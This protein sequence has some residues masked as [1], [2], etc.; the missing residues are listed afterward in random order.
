MT[1]RL[2]KSTIILLAC[3]LAFAAT[4]CRGMRIDLKQASYAPAFDAAELKAYKGKSVFIYDIANNAS[5]TSL[6]DYYSPTTRN[7]YEAWPTMRTYFWDCFVKA[8]N[9][10]G[11]TVAADGAGAPSFSLSFTTLNEEEMVFDVNLAHAGSAPFVKNYK[12]STP[13]ADPKADP[14]S[15]EKRAYRQVDAAFLAVMT[16][17][18][19]RK[20]F[21][22]K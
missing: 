14:A 20:A 4:G 2:G 15:L 18:D 11:V 7:Y 21:L 9:L 10:A 13:P 19:F 16:D 22:K 6:W 17:P 3:A 12:V 5:G 1:R 8:F